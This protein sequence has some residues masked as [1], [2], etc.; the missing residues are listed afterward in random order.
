MQ[1]IANLALNSLTGEFQKP[2]S[3]RGRVWSPPER[4][5]CA[6]RLQAC[7]DSLGAALVERIET[8][9]LFGP[10]VGSVSRM[11]ACD[12]ASTPRTATGCWAGH[13]S[14]KTPLFADSS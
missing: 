11:W 6:L 4:L 13:F 5:I 10:F 3:P 12:A 8:D 9:L 7:I 1:Q 14:V 2:Y